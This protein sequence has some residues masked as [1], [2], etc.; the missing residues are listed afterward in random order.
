MITLYLLE[1]KS[2]KVYNDYVKTGA[3]PSKMEAEMPL[4]GPLRPDLVSTSVGSRFV[5]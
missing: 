3:Q 2:Y 4:G 1:K 5:I